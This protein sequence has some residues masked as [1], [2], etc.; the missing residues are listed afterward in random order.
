MFSSIRLT[1]FD[2][3]TMPGILLPRYQFG[4]AKIYLLLGGRRGGDRMIVL[5]TTAYA[6]VPIT[7]KAVSFN[8]AHSE[9]YSIPH[10]VI[11]FVS[12]LRQVCGFLRVF[13]FPPPI[14][15]WIFL[16]RHLKAAN[17]TWAP[18]MR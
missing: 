17:I 7:T 13:R 11:K 5:F 2:N 8:S 9:V 16:Y 10:Y 1:L 12:D 18:Y 6:I 15:N 4:V 3:W 14:Y